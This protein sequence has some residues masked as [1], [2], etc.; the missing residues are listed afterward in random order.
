MT[1]DGPREST[2][3]GVR[4]PAI[5]LLL[6]IA[7][8]A[9]GTAWLMFTPP[10]TS[11][12]KAEIKA[13]APGL[14]RS[15][16]KTPEK[17]SPIKEEAKKKPP[18]EPDPAPPTSPPVQSA[19]EPKTQPAAIATR[20]K[21]PAGKKLA[22]KPE[23]QPVSQST[24]QTSSPEQPKEEKKI[25]VPTEPS[26]PKTVAVAPIIPA[27]PKLT[28][29]RRERPLR[30][31]PDPAL[32]E[33]S[34]SGPLPIVGRDGR[35]A[36]RVYARPFRGDKSKPRIAIVLHGLG[37]S[38]TASRA[39]IQGL[40]GVITLAFTPY[41]DRLTGWIREA[42]TAGH[43]VLLMTPME[44]TNYPQFDPG[45]QALLTT[46]T[47]QENIGRLHWILGRSVGYVGVVDFMGSRFTRSHAQMRLVLAALR[48][49]GLLYLESRAAARNIVGD[50]A[51]GLKLPFAA[52]TLH[53]D[54]TASR[55]AIDSQLRETER[56]AKKL[57]QAVALGFPY[58]VTLERVGEW[59]KSVEKRGIVL[60]PISAI[61]KR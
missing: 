55:L 19:I 21:Q 48:K 41:A 52:A 20:P 60:V 14:K 22:A 35:E 17:T 39:A 31:V 59:A 43:E 44:P 18:V 1:D 23:K 29:E 15:E 40:P 37:T 9:G 57:G 10:P 58:P 13:S 7:I 56:L 28:L 50:I 46:L 51:K 24:P 61:A 30:A 3:S 2:R 8:S 53:L 47:D 25:E 34:V 33:K 36:W 6:L 16:S 32:I 27:V 12:E 26:P 5:I 11:E 54:K 45:P 4:L 42:R 38:V 49:R